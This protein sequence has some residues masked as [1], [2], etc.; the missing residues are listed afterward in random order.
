MKKKIIQQYEFEFALGDVV[1]FVTDPDENDFVITGY[2]IHGETIF[3]EVSCGNNIK[4]EHL[5]CE[6]R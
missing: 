5:A 1:R 2:I 4:S 3:Y 6:L